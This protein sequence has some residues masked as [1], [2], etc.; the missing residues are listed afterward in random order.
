MLNAEILALF[1]PAARSQLVPVRNPAPLRLKG[2][3]R[4]WA[5]MKAEERFIACANRFI[6]DTV[7]FEQSSLHAAHVALQS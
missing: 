5:A 6:G 4:P 1:G 7:L 2:G 3:I